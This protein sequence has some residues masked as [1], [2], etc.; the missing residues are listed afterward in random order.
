MQKR[1]SGVFSFYLKE[2][3]WRAMAEAEMKRIP[4]VWSEYFNI[5]GLP[6]RLLVCLPSYLP[7]CLSAYLSVCLP[8]CTTPTTQSGLNIQHQV[9]VCLS[10]Y[11]PSC[12]YHPYHTIRPE[13]STLSVCPPVSLSACL[14]AYLPS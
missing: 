10:A 2:K 3:I 7:T 12:L 6:A 14:S 13:H 1:R 5:K 8:V 11:L 9:S 4:D